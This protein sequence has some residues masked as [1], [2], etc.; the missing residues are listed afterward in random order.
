MR[1]GLVHAKHRAQLITFHDFNLEQS[2]RDAFEEI[3][4]STLPLGISRWVH[5][6]VPARVRKE[7]DIP[8]T[9]V[10][11]VHAAV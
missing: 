6:D 5:L 2:S 11:A 1:C 7:T 4:I 10:V 8:V 9:H 3:I